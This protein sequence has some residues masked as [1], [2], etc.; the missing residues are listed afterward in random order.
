MNITTGRDGKLY[1]SW[2]DPADRMRVIELAHQLRCREG[3]SVRQ[4]QRRLFDH[5]IRR[6]V[7]MIHQYLANF[8]CPACS[9]M[10]EPV[11]GPAAPCCRPRC[12]HMVRQQS[13][14][15]KR[16]RLVSLNLRPAAPGAG[17]CP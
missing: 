13:L 9:D 16:Q 6:S 4:I 7:G 14:L 8:E 15:M 11:A 10:P 1:M 12:L 5:H 17:V 3:L 2:R